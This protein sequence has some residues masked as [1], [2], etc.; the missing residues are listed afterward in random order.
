FDA[1]E[2]PATARTRHQLDELLVNTVGTRAAAPI[3]LFGRLE[4]RMTEGSHA[5]AVNREHVVHQLKTVDSVGVPYSAHLL[6][7][8]RRALEPETPA[9]E[10]IGGAKRARKRTAA[11]QLQRHETARFHV[12]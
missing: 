11:S 5:L 8:P 3:K 12:R 6:E 10:I 7:H 4:Q 9:E 1:E 2:D